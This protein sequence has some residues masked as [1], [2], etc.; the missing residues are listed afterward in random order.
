[1]RVVAH[2]GFKNMNAERTHGF[3]KA[4]RVIY[5]LIYVLDKESVDL[6]LQW[7]DL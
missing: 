7:L 5:V 3:C 2:K 6:R 4:K 1:M